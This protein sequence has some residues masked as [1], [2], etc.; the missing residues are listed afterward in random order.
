MSARSDRSEPG[1]GRL[2]VAVMAVILVAAGAGGFY[3]FSVAGAP[4]PTATAPVETQPAPPPARPDEPFPATLFLPADNR[5]AAV[6][7]AVK[8]QPD[9]QLQAREVVAAL[10][11]DKQ[12]GRAAVLKELRLRALFVDSAGTAFLDLGPRAAAQKEM[13]SS[14]EDE[15]LALYA[16]VNTVTQNIP[17]VRQV[18]IIVDGREAQ[19]LAGHIDL[20]RSFVKRTDLVKTP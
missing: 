16:L 8:R 17:E 20:S 14:V 12:T 15:L 11:D 18:R 10:L 9:A 7:V 4:R 13:R 19:T 1:S 2:I 5:L 6:P 3:W